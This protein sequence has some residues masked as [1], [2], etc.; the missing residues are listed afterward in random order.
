MHNAPLYRGLVHGSIAGI[1]DGFR[2]ADVSG[3]PAWLQLEQGL[4]GGYT[5]AIAL[6]GGFQSRKVS[7]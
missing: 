4:E 7:K 5:I 6:I 2:L 1:C 3:E